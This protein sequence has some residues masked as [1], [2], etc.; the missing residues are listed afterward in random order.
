MKRILS[1]LAIFLYGCFFGSTLNFSI[2]DTEGKP[3]LITN[4][5][6]ETGDLSR[7][8]LPE[9]WTVLENSKLTDINCNNTEVI[10]GKSSLEI[11]SESRTVIISDAFKIAKNNAVYANIFVKAKNNSKQSVE[12]NIITFDKYGKKTGIYPSKSIISDEWKELSVSAGFFKSNTEFA[13][14]MIT[15]P[16]DSE[17]S[18]Y[19]DNCGA[20]IVHEF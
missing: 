3:N 9:E 8:K 18:F 19:I 5:D 17:N 15:I 14:I 2:K 16:K 20:F 7:G 11:S 4:G 12:L 1:L 10:S 13:R 6:F